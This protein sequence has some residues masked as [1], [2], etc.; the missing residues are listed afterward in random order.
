MEVIK[1]G[2]K[3][4]IK[5]NKQATMELD[6]CCGIVIY[7]KGAAGEK[8]VGAAHCV[9]PSYFEHFLQL[10]CYLSG[11]ILPEDFLTTPNKA[12]SAL[13]SLLKRKN[14]CALTA[15]IA[16]CQLG[17]YGYD[18]EQEAR[19]ALASEHIPVLNSRLTGLSYTIGLVVSVDFLVA[20]F[21][22]PSDKSVV[23]PARKVP[24]VYN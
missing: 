11:I 21:L 2:A 15:I 3:C 9:V 10:E 6:T 17:K 24:L 19:N 23:Y 12:V 8:L 4:L 20:Q 22:E 13:L 16:G 7:G 5:G 18:N 1:E 14:P